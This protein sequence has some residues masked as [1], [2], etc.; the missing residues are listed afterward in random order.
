MSENQRKIKEL[1]GLMQVGE[2]LV[3]IIDDAI[4]W[5]ECPEC[6][7][8]TTIFDSSEEVLEAPEFY[9]E[10]CEEVKVIENERGEE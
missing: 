6:G 2:A 9:C 10:S 1:Q 7:E 3:D 5:P 4:D 8:L